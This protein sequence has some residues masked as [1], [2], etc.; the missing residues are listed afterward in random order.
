MSSYSIWGFVLKGCF[1][2]VCFEGPNH[3][4]RALKTSILDIDEHVG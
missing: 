2:I 1:E 3:I 4:W